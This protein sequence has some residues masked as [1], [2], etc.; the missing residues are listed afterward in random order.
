MLQYYVLYGVKSGRLSPNIVPNLE[1]LLHCMKAG[2]GLVA[3]LYMSEIRLY[4]DMWS[5]ESWW[6]EIGRCKC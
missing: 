5:G 2:L 1:F 4:G 3:D 6:M